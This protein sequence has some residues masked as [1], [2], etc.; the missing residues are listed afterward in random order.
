MLIE[1]SCECCQVKFRRSLSDIHKGERLGYKHYCSRTCSSKAT[2]ERKLGHFRGDTQSD[3][4]TPFR[5][6]MHRIGAQARTAR[7]K[8]EDYCKIT[9]IDLVAQWSRQNG[10]CPYTGWQLELPIGRGMP[11]EALPTS[12][13]LDR[14]DSKLPYQLDNIEF[15]SLMAQYAKN[16]FR[17]EDVIEFCLA[18]SINCRGGR[19]SSKALVNDCDMVV[20]TGEGLSVPG[21]IS[22]SCDVGSTPT[23]SIND[24]LDV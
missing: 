1:L 5:V 8:F 11:R 9:L 19:V 7:R 4:F 13:S 10:I 21:S 16:K 17:R 20:A 2:Y 6:F 22:K 12:A 24:C 15:V 3:Q 18:V 23:R 14:I